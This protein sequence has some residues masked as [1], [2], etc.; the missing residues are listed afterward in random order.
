MRLGIN[1]P[2]SLHKRIRPIKDKINV[3]Q[4]CR[5]AIERW[6]NAYE[7]SLDSIEHDDLS[8]K[9]SQLKSAWK[10]IDIDWEEIG[11][12]DAKIWTEKATP[13]D[14]A[15]FSHNLRVGRGHGRIPG[16][17]MAGYLPDTPHYYDRQHEHEEWFIQQEDIDPDTNSYMVAHEEYERGWT[18]YLIAILDLAKEDKQWIH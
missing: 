4:I 12:Q 17:W 3:S 14:F 7:S 18:S 1:I 2:N 10:Y 11:R 8:G 9:I 15:R 16:I 6:V 13:E 5:D